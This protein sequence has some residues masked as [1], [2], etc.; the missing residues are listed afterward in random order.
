[1]SG[2]ERTHDFSMTAME[3]EIHSTQGK[4]HLL[5]VNELSEIPNKIIKSGFVSPIERKKILSEKIDHQSL[6]KL[7]KEIQNLIDFQS[8]RIALLEIPTND[9]SKNIRL[10]EC[11]QL[12]KLEGVPVP[13]LLLCKKCTK[14][15]AR[16]R[17]TS[18]PI[19]R[20]LKQHEKVE[21]ARKEQKKK[22]KDTIEGTYATYLRQAMKNSLPIP[23]VA[24]ECAIKL[25]TD[26]KH[27]IEK[28]V[29]DQGEREARIRLSKKLRT[30]LLN[31]ITFEKSE[32]VRK[33][34]CKEIRQHPEIYSVGKYP[35]KDYT[36]ILPKAVVSQTTFNEMD[37]KR[38]VTE[39]IMPI[40]MPGA[41]DISSG[42][43]P[44]PKKIEIP[45]LE[46]I[47]IEPPLNEEIG[48]SPKLVDEHEIKVDIPNS[49]YISK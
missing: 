10:A 14:V 13:E 22:S 5:V 4:K 26:F 35:Q 37:A 6:L 8:T 48:I 41:T 23:S 28:T 25:S 33:Q 2:N 20:H 44:F 16:C 17:L 9:F 15:M 7:K 1:M 21:M 43:V 32:K 24:Q 47:S 12:I 3:A 42:N 30:V 36:Q 31:K 19:V 27:K 49:K 18:T 40:T 38:Y 34:L 45:D 46:I 39:K 11:F 29:L